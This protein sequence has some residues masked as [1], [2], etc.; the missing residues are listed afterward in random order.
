M[1][2]RHGNMVRAKE[3]VRRN[4][5]LMWQ[6][7]GQGNLPLHLAVENVHMDVANYLVEKDPQSSWALNGAHISP[8][9]LA[10]EAQYI[11]VVKHVL[12]MAGGHNIAPTLGQGM[13]F[14]IRAG[15]QGKPVNK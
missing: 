11:D 7:N 12:R 3:A 1:A 15:N 6:R 13:S 9:Y 4:R 14:A 5:E 8:I 2:A 10:V